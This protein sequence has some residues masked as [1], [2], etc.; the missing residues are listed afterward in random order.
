MLRTYPESTTVIECP[1]VQPCPLHG[2]R[3][4]VAE[5][6]VVNREVACSTQAVGSTSMGRR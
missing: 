5:H 4:S 3:S 2:P 6:P 1:N